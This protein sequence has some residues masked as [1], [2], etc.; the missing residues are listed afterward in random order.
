MT[1]P[2]TYQP[3]GPKSEDEW[4]PFSSDAMTVTFCPC[5]ETHVS[6]RTATDCPW[7]GDDE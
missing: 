6:R 4:E 1:D 5:G 3:P 7:A 2:W